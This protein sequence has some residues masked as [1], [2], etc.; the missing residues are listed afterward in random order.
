MRLF[1]E[2]LQVG[3]SALLLRSQMYQNPIGGPLLDRIDIQIVCGVA[4]VVKL[5]GQEAEKALLSCGRV[6]SRR[7]AFREK[8]ACFGEMA[9]SQGKA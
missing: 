6:L 5:L 9:A 8:R 7:E 2:I 4:I 3:A 1:L